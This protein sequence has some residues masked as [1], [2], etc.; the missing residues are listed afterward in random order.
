MYI[1]KIVMLHD[2]KTNDLLF[3]WLSTIIFLVFLMIIVGGYT[4]LTDSGLSI[5]KWELFTGILPPLSQSDWENYFNLYKK[6][7]QYQ[8]VNPLMTLQEFKIILF[9]NPIFFASNGLLFIIIIKID[10]DYIYTIGVAVEINYS[11]S[12][13]RRHIS[14]SNNNII[15]I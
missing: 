11:K 2:K 13:R 14:S 1:I 8:I 9:V 6:I 5:T 3:Y 4:R 10:A 7:P 12:E 15:I